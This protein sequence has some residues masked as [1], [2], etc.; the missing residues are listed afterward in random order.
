MHPPTGMAPTDIHMNP[1][2]AQ[3]HQKGIHGERAASSS[4]D[5]GE[6]SPHVPVF[7]G[8][9]CGMCHAGIGVRGGAAAHLCVEVKMVVVTAFAATLAA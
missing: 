7:V 9:R 5:Y 6:N 1:T 3:Q 2:A 4:S 8:R